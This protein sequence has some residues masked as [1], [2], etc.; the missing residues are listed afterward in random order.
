MLVCL[1]HL[2]M[3]RHY[4]QKLEGINKNE[5]KQNFGE[6]IECELWLRTWHPWGAVVRKTYA[7]PC[8]RFIQHGTLTHEINKTRW[9]LCNLQQQKN[10]TCTRM[11]A[12][13]LNICTF[14]SWSETETIKLTSFV[15][16]ILHNSFRLP[17][18]LT[19]KCSLLQ[20]L[21]SKVMEMKHCSCKLLAYL[22]ERGNNIKP[23]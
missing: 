8:S 2:Q 12:H 6:Q 16:L 13:K 18:Q 19:I 10:T 9:V 14:T 11:T 3:K 23:G 1:E 22:Q 7:A 17:F 21:V 4:L 5:A 15:I 20:R